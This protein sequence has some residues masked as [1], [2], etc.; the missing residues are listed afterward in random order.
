[1]I[2]VR[3]STGYNFDTEISHHNEPKMAWYEKVNAVHERA[4]CHAEVHIWRYQQILVASHEPFTACCELAVHLGSS[5]WQAHPQGFYTCTFALASLPV[6]VRHSMIVWPPILSTRPQ[7]CSSPPLLVEAVHVVHPSLSLRC[8]GPSLQSQI[9]SMQS[10][11]CCW[12]AAHAH[13]LQPLPQSL[14]QE[15]QHVPACRH[16][17]F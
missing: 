14:H 8:A 3:S 17:H 4:R 12:N 15:R 7:I 1:M 2:D 16:K 10:I 6:C 11:P 9:P 13:V 5:E